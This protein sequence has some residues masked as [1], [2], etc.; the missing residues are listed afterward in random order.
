[1]TVVCKDRR[2]EVLIFLFLS[3]NTVFDGS[4]LL[5]D[6]GGKSTRQFKRAVVYSPG[7]RRIYYMQIS[8]S[9]NGS[10]YR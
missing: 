7:T 1:M 9:T 2:L 10:Y 8:I 5:E 4:S 6:P 3:R